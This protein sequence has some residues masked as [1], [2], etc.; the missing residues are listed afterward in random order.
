MG[1]SIISIRVAAPARLSSM[2]TK[3]ASGASLIISAEGMSTGGGV[4]MWTGDEGM[5]V[6]IR[7]ELIVSCAASLART[8]LREA[9]RSPTDSYSSRMELMVVMFV[10]E[11][12]GEGRGN[13]LLALFHPSFMFP[14]A[15]LLRW[16]I[17]D[18]SRR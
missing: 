11:G 18:R 12:K 13:V 4:A 16:G 2:V 3:L 5:I 9:P 1:S 7:G 6:V 10:C 8:A 17:G 15:L 14:W